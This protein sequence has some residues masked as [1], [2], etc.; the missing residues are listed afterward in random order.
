[1]NAMRPFSLL[2]VTAA[3]WL[4]T[5]PPVSAHALLR[6]AVPPV[7]A[8]VRTAPQ[9]VTIS[10]TEAVEP[11]FSTII[12]QDAAGNR[13]DAGDTHANPADGT[14]LSVGLKA[15]PPGTYT[16]IWHVTSVDTHKTEGKFTITVAP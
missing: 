2:A 8:T 13:V 7:G 14:Q 10:F 12:V 11:R 4:A 15:L 9:E 3:L 16:V 1:M 5:A 6:R